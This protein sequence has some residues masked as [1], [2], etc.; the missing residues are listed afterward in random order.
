[1]CGLSVRLCARV[2]AFSRKDAA[3]LQG[4]LGLQVFDDAFQALSSFSLLLQLP[5]QLLTI[6]FCLLQLHMKLFNLRNT[7]SSKIK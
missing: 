3:G 1:M 6:G 2:L 5:S 4:Q 7:G